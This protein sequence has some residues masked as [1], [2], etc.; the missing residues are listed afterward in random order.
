MSQPSAPPH[1]RPTNVTL[2]KP[3]HALHIQ[4]TDNHISAYPL[5][6]LREACPCALCRGGHEFMGPQFDP[7][8]IELKPARSYEVKDM[9]LIGNYA[10]MFV[11]SDLHSSGIYTWDYL[12][13][14]C[15][16]PICQAEREI[17]AGINP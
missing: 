3:D 9:Q 14:I 7:N 16:C 17:K 2:N 6:E 8:L 5:N 15:P 4:W 13:R 11:W 10:L 1:H 12:R